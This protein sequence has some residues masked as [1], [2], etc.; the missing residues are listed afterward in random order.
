MRKR[1]GAIGTYIMA[2]AFFLL[3]PCGPLCAQPVPQVTAS[4]PAAPLAAAANGTVLYDQNNNCSATGVSSQ[5]FTDPGG[6]K[7]SFDAQAADDF[8]VPAPGWAVTTVEVPGRYESGPGPAESVNVFFYADAGGLP[9]VLEYSAL[10]VTP[11]AGLASGSFTIDLPALVT[12]DPGTHWVSVQANQNFTSAGQWFWTERTV[13]SGNE[14]A[15]QN[16][17]DGFGTGCT[18]WG[19]GVTTCGIRVSPDLCFTLSGGLA[20]APAPALSPYGLGAGLL[21]LL[22]AGAVAFR[23]LRAV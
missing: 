16:P 8:V 18:T 20:S 6:V 5:N 11:S 22:G 7:D 21:V 4:G 2:G 19:P 17:G 14:Y 1:N 9:G 10:G 3:A 15:W 13:Q 23:R 12:L